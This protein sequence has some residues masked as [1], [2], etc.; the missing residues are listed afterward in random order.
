MQKV[1]L[2]T[3]KSKFL[4]TT[5]LPECIQTMTLKLAGGKK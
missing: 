2:L 1:T 4:L 5:T 3:A